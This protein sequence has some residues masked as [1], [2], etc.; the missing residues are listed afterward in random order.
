MLLLYLVGDRAAILALG[1]HPRAW[2]VGLMFVL[3]AGFAREYD[4]EDLMHAP[5][6]LLLPL[7][8]SIVSSFL[9]YLVL[10]G[11][12]VL[13]TFR[14]CGFLAAY[15]SFLSLFWLTAPLA[16][17]YA[18]PYERF[19][20]AVWATK[21]N[22]ITLALVAVWRV[23]LMVRVASVLFEM[24]VGVA[25]VRVLAYADAAAL[26]ALAFSPFPI[27]EVMGGVHL[28]QAE[29][30]VREAAQ[31]M[32][33][34]GG[35]TFFVWAALALATVRAPARWQAESQESPVQTRISK[36]V[37]A[38]ASASLAVWLGI[39]PFT[40]PEQRLRWQVEAAFR[41]GLIAEGLTLMSQHVPEDFPPHW[42]PPP[43]F[44]KGDPPVLLLDICK[45]I[46]QSNPQP[47]VRQRF[48]LMLR[49]NLVN[50]SYSGYEEQAAAVLNQLPE[51]K[52]ILFDLRQT[53]RG[54]RLIGLDQYLRPEL[55][56]N[57]I[58]VSK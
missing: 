54:S 13:I 53:P 9:L 11:V 52:A 20:D 14:G 34:L 32:L 24:S 56:S 21:A 17:L 25:L 31:L 40:Q 55:S 42:E 49:E 36:P 22:L 12:R 3:S 41:K 57:T 46:P 27:I 28:S 29:A 4:A 7:G 43:R 51:A 33:C 8:A 19:L 39:L 38:L 48:L 2:I 23:A 30:A 16:W 37:K 10:Y 1:A 50:L 5:W 58:G 44:L 47:W 6:V 18:M 15:R 45:E 35:F 26:L